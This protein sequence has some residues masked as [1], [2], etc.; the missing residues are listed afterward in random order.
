MNSLYQKLI[1]IKNSKN[2]QVINTNEPDIGIKFKNLVNKIKFDNDNN[3]DNSV[4]ID[5]DD[6]EELSNIMK[7]LHINCVKNVNM[8]H[9][10]K[11]KINAL[12][13]QEQK[14]DINNIYMV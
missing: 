12:E 5:I 6:Y 9:N 14:N 7:T 11:E 4:H 1:S 8:I 13:H 10:L 3:N 2:T